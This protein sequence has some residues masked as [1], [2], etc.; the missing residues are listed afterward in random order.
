LIIHIASANYDERQFPDPDHFLI[1]RN[2]NRHLSFGSGI[3]F[4]LGAPLARLEATIAL[5][6]LL[7]RFQQ[8]ERIPGAPVRAIQTFFTFGVEQFPVTFKA[9]K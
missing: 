1:R 9:R 7:E 5:Q 3:H 2:P 6:I 8:I 4:C